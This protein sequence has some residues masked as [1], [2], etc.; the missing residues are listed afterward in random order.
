[1]GPASR[2]SVTRPSSNSSRC[3]PGTLTGQASRSRCANSRAR[4]CATSCAAGSAGN[5]AM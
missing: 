3:K 2:S 5:S 4:S 1:M